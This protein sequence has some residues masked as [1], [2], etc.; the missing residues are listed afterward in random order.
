MIIYRISPIEVIIMSYSLN[1]GKT[2]VEF[3]IPAHW[4]VIAIAKPE[5]IAA[6]PPD[7]LATTIKNTLQ[8][9]IGYPPLKESVNESTTVAIAVDDISRHTPAHLLIEPL[10]DLLYEC[11]VKKENITII[12]ALGMHRKMTE[13]DAQK[14]LGLRIIKEIHWENHELES[15][16]VNLGKS[17]QGTPIFINQNFY[18]A[19]FKIAIGLIEPHL[20]AGYSG[21]AKCVC[22]GLV[23]TDTIAVHHK[24]VMKETVR[25]G[26][27]INSNPFRKD[28]E[29]I[30]AKAGLNLILNCILNLDTQ[31]CH[32]IAGA[33]QAAYERGVELARPVCEVEVPD[34]ADVIISA[35]YPL[36]IDFRQSSKAAFNTQF[37]LRNKGSLIVLS[38][39]VE[40]TGN[41][42]ASDNPPTV[43]KIRTL[44][45]LGLKPLVWKSILKS[46]YGIEDAAGVFQMFK[47]IAKKNFIMCSDNLNEADRQVAWMCSH[48]KEME[49]AIQIAD[50]LIKPSQKGSKVKCIIFPMGGVSY[51]RVNSK[52]ST[53]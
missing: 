30:T 18:K 20:W 31:I 10:I 37:A 51:P 13:E 48:A 19:D 41:L 32:V 9:P 7:A 33:P 38:P 12:F 6:I 45:K 4:D 22:P 39:C 44:F 35:S 43:K 3:T 52:H 23:G 2:E 25:V 8:D 27:N 5:K 36:G 14:K 24:K 15:N 29:D 47:F 34:F 16:L 26:P 42:R 21:G 53:P 11:G 50:Q 40:G 1:Y 28:I 49:E 46:G 17:S